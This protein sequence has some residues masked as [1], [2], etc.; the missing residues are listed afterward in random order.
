[1]KNLPL[2]L[3]LVLLFSCSSGQND[4]LQDSSKKD[5]LDHVEPQR[6]SPVETI[7]SPTTA[8]LGQE[9]E[10]EVNFRVFNGCGQFSEFTQVV[11][12][13]TRTIEVQAVYKGEICTMDIP[14]R[15]TTYR[16]TPEEKGQYTLRFHAGEDQYK[17]AQ[18]QVQ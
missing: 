4:V 10:V 5:R 6:P 15:T 9:I 2:S 13:T 11:S 17:V 18:I 3:C 14:L 1:M 16:F 8:S 12:G 7:K